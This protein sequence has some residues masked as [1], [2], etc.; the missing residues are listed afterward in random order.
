MI[1][2]K[3]M[4]MSV[5]ND[6]FADMIRA[7]VEVDKNEDIHDRYSDYLV[8][9][10]FKSYATCRKNKSVYELENVPKN[11]IKLYYSLDNKT[12]F[13]NVM[14]KFKNRYRLQ[15]SIVEDVHSKVE[16]EG[17]GLVYDYISSDEWKNMPFIFLVI[18]KLH[19]VL[20]SKAPYPEGSGSFRKMPVYLPNSGVP[21]SEPDFIFKEVYDLDPKFKKLLEVGKDIK[22]NNLGG[23]FIIDYINECLKLKC[24]LIRIHPFM[25]GN[26]RVMR[27]LTN[28]LFKEA[29]L[30]PVYV[31]AS[32]RKIYEKAMNKA[33]VNNDYTNIN[34]FYYYRIC[35]S[36]YTLD[37]E[38]RKKANASNNVLNGDISNNKLKK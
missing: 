27:A 33:I 5:N 2:A 24:E 28:I 20:F 4:M 23:E 22:D 21:T 9:E 26:G 13:S 30:P 38:G 14:D 36:I 25:D 12:D 37:I 19:S 18:Q 31:K 8:E 1:T 17:L 34:N 11:L 29:G 16:R 35:D 32:Q 15:E 3:N 6:K 10:Y 7:L